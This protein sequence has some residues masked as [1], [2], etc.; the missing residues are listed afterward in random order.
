MFEIRYTPAIE[1]TGARRQQVLSNISSV[2]AA[3]RGR[4]V[5]LTSGTEARAD[6]LRGPYDVM[7]LAIVLGLNEVK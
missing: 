5:I 1:E 7:N 4:G 3:T 2:F 6:L